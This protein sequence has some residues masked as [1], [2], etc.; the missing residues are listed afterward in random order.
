VQFGRTARF[1]SCAAWT[2]NLVPE[3]C[4]SSSYR[5]HKFNFLAKASMRRR[6]SMRWTEAEL[7]AKVRLLAADTHNR[8]LHAP[9]GKV[10]NHNEGSLLCMDCTCYCNCFADI[11]G[12]RARP[13][14]RISPG[15]RRDSS[16]YA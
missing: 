14:E 13:S 6:R 4:A 16:A 8:S 12:S 3:S 9:G 11:C 15:E 1:M 10:S 5:S 2:L 7:L